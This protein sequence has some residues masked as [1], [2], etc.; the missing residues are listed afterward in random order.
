MTFNWN[1]HMWK[2]VLTDFL[3]IWHQSSRERGEQ[4][5]TT[6]VKV[7]DSSSMDT[8]GRKNK[9]PLLLNTIRSSASQQPFTDITL[10]GMNKGASNCFPNG[11]HWH[12][13]GLIL[14]S[15]SRSESPDSLLSIHWYLTGVQGLGAGFSLPQGKD[16]SPAFLHSLFWH[17]FR[18]ELTP[19]G[20]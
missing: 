13:R 19:S 14:T 6:E 11:L 20:T 8:Q 1:L 5:G 3:L 2:L 17:S 10:T 15:L 7:P 9:D 18:K 16:R 4:S 12:C